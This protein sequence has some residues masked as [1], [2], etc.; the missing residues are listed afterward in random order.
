MLDIVAPQEDVLIRRAKT[1][2]GSI[3]REKWR[4]DRL[5]GIGGMAA[6]YAG[7][8]RN[9]KRGAIK[10]LHLELSLDPDARGR[11]LKEGYVA[12]QVNHPGAVSVLD[13]DIAEDGSVFLVM[14]LLEGRTVDAVASERPG[15]RV[16]PAEALNIVDQLLDVL[17]AAHDKG[18]VHRD[19]KPENLFLTPGGVVKVLDFGLARIRELP[20]QAHATR[21][22]NPMGTPAFMPPEQALG[23][24][25]QVDAR[26][27]LW[28]AG[29]TL[30]TMLTGRLVHEAP[31]VNQLMLASM[32]KPAP[33]I[34]GVLPDLPEAVAALVDRSLA[35]N[36]EKRWQSAREMQRA[37][38]EIGRELPG[39]TDP[40]GATA[41][42]LDAQ[43]SL[44]ESPSLLGTTLL[45][46]AGVRRPKSPLL[47][48]VIACAAV[49][50]VTLLAALAVLRSAAPPPVVATGALPP[51]THAA[52]LREPAVIPSDVATVAP[53]V[54]A[55]AEAPSAS[56]SAAPAAKSAPSSSAKAPPKRADPAP[57]KTS[58]PFL[59]WK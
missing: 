46:D 10:I 14:E 11:F 19:L 59:E 58:D 32:T 18:I 52:P 13:D 33:R 45:R 1:R 5:L 15:Q 49:L 50:A 29:A 7:T 39:F 53:H 23:N 4:I 43:P 30:F 57:A 41:S 40:P 47:R 21:T 36:R 6:V 12:N 37:L 54:A 44:P 26:T 31:T 38:R 56:A 9:G 17:S 8:H 25:E 48:V 22:G 51:S 35:F 16:S 55:P 3:L 20:G 34:R 42:R 28:A 2:I 24:W 27:D